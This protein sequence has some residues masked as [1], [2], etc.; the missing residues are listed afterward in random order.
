[1]SDKRRRL[2][3]L[4]RHSDQTPQ[5][6]WG[7][8]QF[9]AA[10]ASPDSRWWVRSLADEPLERYRHSQGPWSP[11]QVRRFFSALD[12]QARDDAMFV[13]QQYV[14]PALSGASLSCADFRISEGVA[15]P[16]AALLRDGGCG[17]MIASVKD[18][19]IW[20]LQRGALDEYLS[21]GLALA[22]ASIPSGQDALWEW[23]VSAS[24]AVYHVDRKLLPSSFLL[25]PPDNGPPE[26][27]RLGDETNGGDVVALV[28]ASIE[29]LHNLGRGTLLVIGS[30]SPM[31]HLCFEAVCRGNAVVLKTAVEAAH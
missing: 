18:R 23:I 26:C 14:E 20:R 4:T 19:V 2:A 24:G 6:Y 3:D 22:H 17:D 30:G 8:E 10:E 11:E 12:N 9:G 7:Y 28:S 15:G 1:V 13:V 27:W 29:H 31:A 5:T 16:A 21:Q 25:N